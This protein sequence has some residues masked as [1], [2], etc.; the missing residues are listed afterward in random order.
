[1]LRRTP[2]GPTRRSGPF[3]VPAYPDRGPRAGAEP[4]DPWGHRDPGHVPYPVTPPRGP[5]GP[6]ARARAF[7]PE[8]QRVATRRCGGRDRSWS[9]D[10]AGT[11]TVVASPSLTNRASGCRSK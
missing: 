7:G 8:T 3:P 1:M 4:P 5:D 11:V 6:C 10:P 9:R 2:R